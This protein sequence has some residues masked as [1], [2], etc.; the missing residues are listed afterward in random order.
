MT[1]TF[2]MADLAEKLGGRLI[3]DG[4]VAVTRVAHPADVCGDGVLAL[5]MDPSLVP[6]LALGG[7]RAAVLSSEEGAAGL[8]AAIVIG[9]A[10][11]ALSVLTRLFEEKAA[12]AEGIHPTAIVEEG[13]RIA[14]D[15]RIGAHSYVG[16]GAHIG[17]GCLI[18]PQ[19]YIGAGAMVGAGC[20]IYAGARI[21]ARVAIGA[22]AIVHFNASIGA[23]GFSFATPERGSVES[24]KET[25]RGGGASN[26]ALLRIASLGA[27]VLGDDVEVGANTSID[28]GTIVSTTIDSGTKIDNQVQIGHN[29]RVGKN[30]M[31]CG[32]V[33][34]AGSAV[35]GDRVVLGGAVGVADHVEIG[36]DSV[37][38]AMSGIAANLPPRS[39]V[40]GA[41]A[42]PRKKAIQDMHSLNR[43]PALMEKIK[44]LTRRLEALEKRG[45]EGR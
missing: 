7:A 14:P 26:T 28:R 15:A 6:L 36:D 31:I 21:G 12:L 41:P 13:A 27:V 18:H 2:T 10:R 35:I 11:V 34:I 44:D 45:P 16:A 43:I 32:R 3:G 38:M 20:E 29:V 33:G 22:R 19:V 42:K 24:A 40:F 30:C 25:G 9:R 39:L 1:K 37:A 4:A 5:A 23:D 8:C 17:A